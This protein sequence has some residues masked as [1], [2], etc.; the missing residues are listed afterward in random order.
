MVVCLLII[1]LACA[2]LAGRLGWRRLRRVG[3]A[4][5]LMI[6]LAV[7]CGPV[8]KILLPYWQAPYVQRP[9]LDWAPANAIV[10]LTAGST[11][12]PGGSLEPGQ[13]AYSRIAQ[14]VMLYRSCRAA[15]V[16]CTVLVSGGDADDTGEPLARTYAPAL[17]KLGVPAEDL[18]L[19]SRSLTTWDNARFARDKLRHIGANRIWL[20]SS[21][22]HLRRAVFAFRHFGMAVTA[23]RSDYLR[24]QW[25][26]VPG[27][28]NFYVTDTALHE[29]VGMAL[30]RWYAWRGSAQVPPERA[31]SPDD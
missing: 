10:L 4:L 22:H 20:V 19:E 12:P 16:R 21:A 11:D 1:L 23:V 8:P 15:G 17:M 27:T 31:G 26:A 6:V 3:Y 25:S 29:Y 18:V 5:V 9:T 13:T 30:Y 7:G 2:W 28:Y 24:G 14:T